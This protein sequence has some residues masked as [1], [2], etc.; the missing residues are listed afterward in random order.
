MKSVHKNVR[1]DQYAFAGATWQKNVKYE[2]RCTVQDEAQHFQWNASEDLIF[3][4]ATS[5][6]E[7]NKKVYSEIHKK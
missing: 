6:I 5:V 2:L 3:D 7:Q 4:I 1:S